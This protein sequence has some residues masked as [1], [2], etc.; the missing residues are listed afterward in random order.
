LQTILAFTHVELDV[1]VYQI[2]NPIFFK[3]RKFKTLFI[4]EHFKFKKYEL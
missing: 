3:E 2:Q 1:D 4:S